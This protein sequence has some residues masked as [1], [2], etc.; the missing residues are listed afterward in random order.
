MG[1]QLQRKVLVEVELLLG[2]D[3]E[4]CSCLFLVVTGL[5]PKFLYA[6]LRQVSR[7][8]PSCARVSGKRLGKGMPSMRG[9]LKC[10]PLEETL[11]SASSYCSSSMIHWMLSYKTLISLSFASM[12]FTSWRRPRYVSES[13]FISLYC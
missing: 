11:S 7:S 5:H 1:V 4:G 6:F 12:K 8:L 3:F 2:Q 13:C 9:F 10:F